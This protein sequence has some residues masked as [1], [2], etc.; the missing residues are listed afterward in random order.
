MTT[1]Q[2]IKAI[3]QRYVD[4]FILYNEVEE[5]RLTLSEEPESLHKSKLMIEL[6]AA[7]VSLS[8]AGKKL[9]DAILTIMYGDD[10]VNDK[11]TVK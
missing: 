6:Y 11:K 5:L 10:F 4:T 1:E 2:K 9:N 7:K 3:R 8:G